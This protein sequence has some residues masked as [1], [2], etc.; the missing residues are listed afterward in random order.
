VR[1]FAQAPSAEST[2]RGN[3]STFSLGVLA[4]M[5]VCAAAFLGIGAPAASAA[6]EAQPAYGYQTT[7]GSGELTPFSRVRNPITVDGSGNVFAANESSGT[8]LV[9]SPGG[10]LLTTL[11]LGPYPADIAI[12][13]STD[14]LYIQDLAVFGSIFRFTSDGNSPP[15]YS[16]DAGFTPAAPGEG[17]AVDPSTGDLLVA[18]GG[19]EDIRRYDTSGTLLATIATPSIAPQRIAVAPDGSIYVSQESSTTVIHLSGSGTVLGEVED[20]GAVQALAVNPETNGLV[21]TADGL[22]K[23]FSSA[24]APLSAAPE[25]HG[26]E[27]GL[28]IDGSSGRLYAFTGSAINAYLPGTQPGVEAPGVS[29]IGTRSAHLSAEVDPGAGPP[30]GSVAYFEYSADDG[31]SW[32]KTPAESV[33]RTVTDEPDTIEADLTGL[34][35]NTEYLVRVKASNA[36]ISNTSP[37]TAFTTPEIAPE[38]ETGVASDLSETSAVL[39]G[40]VN[41]AG[42]QT[43]YHFEYGTTTAYGSRIPL[44]AEGPAGNN[45]VPVNVSRFISGLQPGVTYHYRLVATNA[46][47]ETAGA[48]RTFTTLTSA[49]VFPQRFYEQVTPVDKE[50]AQ[51]LSD[52]HVQAAD[53]GSAIAVTTVQAPRNTESSLMLQNELSRRGADGWLNWTSIDAPQDAMPGLNE[54][55]TA[56]IS[57]DFKHALVISNRVLAPGGIA[58]GGNLY[59][60]DLLTGDYTFVAGAPGETAWQ[61]LI[62]IQQNE[63]IFMAA[64]PDFS[65]IL[66]WGIPQFLPEASGPAIYRWTRSGGDLKLESLLPGE[67][68]PPFGVQLPNS[69]Q[70]E[71][72]ASTP[73]GSVIAYGLPSGVYRRENGQ[74]KA[75]SVSHIP[76]D[77]PTEARPAVFDG[78]TPDG[79]YVFFRSGARLTE[80]TPETG[81]IY[82][83]RYDAVTNGL[84]FLTPANGSATPV[85]GFGEDG[86]TI[87]VENAPSGVLVWHAG[88]VQLV[89]AD[90]P[91]QMFK[92]SRTTVSSNGHFLAWVK[93]AYT[94]PVGEEEGYLYDV[95]TDEVTCFSCPIGGG[96]SG[97]THM[98]AIGRSIGNREPQAV[99]DGG[100][101]FFDTTN[102]LLAADHNGAR[103]VYAYQNGHLQLISP[104]NEDFDAF[105]VDASNDGSDVFFQT[106]QGLVGQDTDGESDVYD[107]RIGGGFA[108]QNPPPPPGACAGAECAQAAGQTTAGPPVA[109]AGAANPAVPHKKHKKHKHKKHGKHK[110]HKGKRHSARSSSANQNLGK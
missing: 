20:V 15:T 24:G 47:G 51:V 67:I 86:Q 106:D 60:K 102:R 48:D 11:S 57:E 40:T 17:I 52:F 33:E 93:G 37:T 50:G 80:D 29:N 79:R 92:G 54:A 8:I 31:D 5:F 89:T 2:S 16:E 21:A 25:S 45:R 14:A 69:Y 105:F 94:T 70:R 72:P 3:G 27:I 110:K 87:Y 65:W 107:A 63:K 75:I 26:G 108:S 44:A 77:D 109:T 7:F 104:G 68:V 9:F 19:A 85:L 90:L 35:L 38:V 98:T 100:M 83:Y 59:V 49:E 76:S 39:H 64:A 41:P 66:F 81:E 99:T 43:G 13:P 84:E 4:A 73:D 95:K 91:G 53:D 97:G 55:S 101:V 12:D 56:A 6:P 10:T 58:G 36:L 103:D 46:V 23:V 42:L 88:Q 96:P 28:A 61:Q 22:L 78:M 62:G 32:E 1:A 30:E 18:D 71:L 34:L 74:T 82:L